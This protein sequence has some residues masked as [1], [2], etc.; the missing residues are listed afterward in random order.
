MSQLFSGKDSL[1]F[2][3]IPHSLG[4][5]PSAYRGFSEWGMFKIPHLYLTIDLT[6]RW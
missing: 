4:S 5:N 1:H 2:L 6:F 3:P